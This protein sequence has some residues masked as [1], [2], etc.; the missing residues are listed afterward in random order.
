MAMLL[1]LDATERVLAMGDADPGWGTPTATTQ[2]GYADLDACQAQ[3]A[4][5]ATPEQPYAI[6]YVAA[7]DTFAARPLPLTADQQAAATLRQALADAVANWATLTAAQKD[8]AALAVLR[9]V[10]RRGVV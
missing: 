4:A 10:A 2:R 8:A 7:S 5:Q 9:A 1:S 6:Y 3:C